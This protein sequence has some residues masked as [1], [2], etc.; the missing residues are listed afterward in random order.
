MRMLNHANPIQVKTV[1][2]MGLKEMGLE[3]SETRKNEEQKAFNSAKE[4]NSSNAFSRF[5]LDYTGKDI[6]NLLK[7]AE[8]ERQKARYAEDAPIRA[9]Q[10]RQQA[11]RER[12]LAKEQVERSQQ[13]AERVRQ[14][15]KEAA[16]LR[17]TLKVGTETN[18]GP[19]LEIRGDLIK[20]YRPV[21]SYGNEH[22][23]RREKILPP[24]ADCRFYNGQ[25]QSN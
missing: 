13:L 20:V 8:D 25:Y 12:L 7:P 18:C 10:A 24:S 9:E 5:I 14:L 21:A 17:S 1:E 23:I 4:S 3:E 11:E 16:K 22:W 15:E 2:I 6:A 19:I